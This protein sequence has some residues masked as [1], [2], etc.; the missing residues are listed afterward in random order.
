MAEATHVEVSHRQVLLHSH[1]AVVTNL[2]VVEEFTALEEGVNRRLVC[3][4][5]E[6]RVAIGSPETPK[7]VAGVGNNFP[8]LRQRRVTVALGVRLT[9]EGVFEELRHPG[10]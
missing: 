7:P 1:D 4:L 2:I 10:C 5:N 3:L 8:D 9:F 6:Y